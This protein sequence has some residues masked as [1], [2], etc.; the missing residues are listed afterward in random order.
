MR[1]KVFLDTNVL[2]YLY[3]RDSPEKRARSISI[4]EQGRESFRLVISTQ[5]LQEF[6]VTVARKL[7]KHVSEAEILLAMHKLQE[8]ATIQIDVPLIFDAIDLGK[9]VQLSFWD[10]L[11]TQAAL[12]AGCTRLLT[13]DL[14]H[15][16][17]IG[18]LTIENPFLD[19]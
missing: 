12:V 2:V 16:L 11:I 13:E 14:Q 18:N 5:V 19:R 17:R 10:A 4:L 3:D 15:G 8:F 9:R 1:D 7:S 6:Y